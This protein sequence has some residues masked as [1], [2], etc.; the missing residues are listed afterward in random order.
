MLRVGNTA[1]DFALNDK[2]G[3]MYKLKDI[4]SK[5]TVVYFYPKD[6]TP[7]CTIEAVEFSKDLNKFEA[8]NV[9]IIGISGGNEKSKTKFIEKY[10]LKAL[11]LSDPDFS[12][13][14]QYG[15]YGE[16]SFLGKK[17]VGIKR[18]SFL[19]DK[20]KKIL[21]IYEKVKPAEHSKELLKD[22]KQFE[23]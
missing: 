16:K 1:T 13:C 14:K 17:F 6:N 9:K 3:K 8:L 5:Y 15:V 11:L 7:G 2:D 10:K 21:K 23:S 22:I 4:K 18:M 19:L 12:V 20:N